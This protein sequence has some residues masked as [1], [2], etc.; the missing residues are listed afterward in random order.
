MV[1]NNIWHTKSSKGISFLGLVE[2]HYL[3]WFQAPTTAQMRSSLF[4]VV[5]RSFIVSHRRFGTTYLSRLGL[6]VFLDCLTLEDG[7]D[8]LFRNVGN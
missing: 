2:T 4:W 6:A 7:T 3:A 5:T 8:W 1:D